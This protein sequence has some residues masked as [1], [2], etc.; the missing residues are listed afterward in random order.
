MRHTEAQ[1]SN[2]TKRQLFLCAVVI[3][4][5]KWEGPSVYLHVSLQI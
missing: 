1:T 4:S 3:K 5:M 2:A